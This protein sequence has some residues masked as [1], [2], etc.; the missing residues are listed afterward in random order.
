MDFVIEVTMFHSKQIRM[1]LFDTVS[2][3]LLPCKQQCI[4]ATWNSPFT[5]FYRFSL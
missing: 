3:I 1:P 4:W 5:E 2:W